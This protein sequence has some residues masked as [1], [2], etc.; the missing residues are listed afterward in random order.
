MNQKPI[1]QAK[2]ADIRNA[3]AA[4]QRAAKRAREVAQ[5]THTALVLNRQGQMIKVR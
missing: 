1:G 5:Q 4:L 3:Q 2:D